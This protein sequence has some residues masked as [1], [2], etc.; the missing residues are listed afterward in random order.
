MK[1][2]S[3][4]AELVTRGLIEYLKKT[5][6]LNILP[7][8]IKETLKKSQTQND[9][10]KA[11]VSTVVELNADQIEEVSRILTDLYKREI[12]VQNIVDPD[13]IA[14]IKIVVGDKVI[15][16]TIKHKLLNLGERLAQ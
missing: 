5:G 10:S 14:G 9:P 13:L 7:Q 16:N 15:D 6:Q 3:K 2:N 12:S 1:A 11:I 8:L 4:K